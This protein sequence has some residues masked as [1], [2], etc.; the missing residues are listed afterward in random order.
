[1]N[2]LS[3]TVLRPRRRPRAR[4]RGPSVIAELLLLAAVVWE[5]LRDADWTHWFLLAAVIGINAGG[6]AGVFFLVEAL[7]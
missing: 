3:E 1:M 7:R 5:R 4:R 6:W 2:A